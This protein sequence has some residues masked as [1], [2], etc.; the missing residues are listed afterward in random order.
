MAIFDMHKPVI[1]QLHGHCLAGGTDIAF[2]CD[3]VIAAEDSIIGQPVTRDFGVAPNQMWLYLMGP[4]WTKRLLLTGDSIS[5][6]DAAKVGLVL[7]AVPS[8]QLESEC[9]NLADR[10]SLIDHHLLSANKRAV[11]LGME[12]M[13][14]RT[15]QRLACEMDGR[16]HLA[17]AVSGWMSDLRNLGP[18]KAFRR[19]NERFGYDVVNVEGADTGKARM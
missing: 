5:G 11:N 18:S 16:G 15:L 9:E 1:C 3:I 14:A 12:L 4:Q 6:S 7:K 8:E 13:G 2:L 17:P 10:M 19:R